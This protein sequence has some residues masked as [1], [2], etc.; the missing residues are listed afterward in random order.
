VGPYYHMEI[1]NHMLL[2]RIGDYW[3]TDVSVADIVVTFVLSLRSIV[4]PHYFLSFYDAPGSGQKQIALFQSQQIIN[5]IIL[6]LCIFHTIEKYDP[7]LHFR[8]L[9]YFD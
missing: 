8:K 5:R 3:N 9:F 2:I 6:N 4:L 7:S 1:K